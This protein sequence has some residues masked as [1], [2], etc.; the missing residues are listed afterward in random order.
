MVSAQLYDYRTA[1]DNL[2]EFTTTNDIVYAVGAVDNGNST[3]D[4]HIDVYEPQGL[5]QYQKA[6]ILY[7]HGGGFTSGDK[8]N[9]RWSCEHFARRG[10]VTFSMQYR[11]QADNPPATGWDPLTSA[12]RAAFVDA[13]AALRW[14]Y[15]NADTYGIDTNNIFI[16]GTSAGAI[17]SLF[18]G[19][20][21]DGEYVTDQDGR[22][23]PETNNPG[24]STDVQGIIDFCGGLYWEVNSIDAG[25]PP[26]LIYH[27][28]EDATVPYTEATAIRDRCVEVGLEHEFYAIQGGGHCPS[29][30]AD[31][32][33]DLLTLT[34][35]FILKHLNS[36]G[37]VALPD[38]IKVQDKSYPQITISGER[39]I[40][41]S[42]NRAASYDLA[43][44]YLYDASGFLVFKTFTELTA[45]QRHLQAN[46]PPG[47]L[48]GFAFFVKLKI[49]GDEY[50]Q[51]IV[52]LR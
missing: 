25:D 27:G 41:V 11:L 29:E 47:T 18:A 23:I 40:E 16:G 31:N 50:I 36:E 21:E 15:A 26:I 14:I 37:P 44:I 34:F 12:M 19:V 32:G 24:Y 38:V 46:I 9:Q 28:T 17:T 35:E 8:S 4:L 6:A 33:K 49:A 30:P 45:G 13:K 3:K 5:D 1:E 52:L 22:S 51:R 20:T 10:F 43:E 42:L 39:T 48:K 2:V 7:I